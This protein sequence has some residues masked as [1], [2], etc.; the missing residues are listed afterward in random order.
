MFYEKNVWR[1][2]WENVV[3][4]IAHINAVLIPFLTTFASNSAIGKENRPRMT[5]NNYE[6]RVF[7]QDVMFVVVVI[8]IVLF[9]VDIFIRGNTVTKKSF[10]DFEVNQANLWWNYLF[11]FNGVCD[12]VAVIGTSVSLLPI[13]PNSKYGS[14]DDDYQKDMWQ[15]GFLFL[16]FKSR[17]LFGMDF[18]AKLG[19]F[20]NRV[21]RL[22]RMF[23]LLLVV[24]HMLACLWKLT[25]DVEKEDN[26]EI[27]SWD[28]VTTLN[29]GGTTLQDADVWQQYQS[30]SFYVLLLMFGENINPQTPLEKLCAYLIVMVGLVTTA[31]VV[32]NMTYYVKIIL[33]D[34]E[35]YHESMDNAEVL[36]AKLML[37]TK[38]QEL[39]REYMK[40]CHRKQSMIAP[41]RYAQFLDGLSDGLRNQVMVE[42]SRKFIAKC[43]LL[44]AFH[45][46]SV[47]LL[48][49][50]FFSS[51]VS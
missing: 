43:W 14:T 1:R 25:N 28:E 27:V 51:V 2:R 17:L 16:L 36:M 9:T 19:V 47:M 15:R 40:Y 21:L 22:T 26:F 23:C 29:D 50:Y 42:T 3:T 8:S 48:L 33:Q 24:V 5:P 7:L 37:P 30:Y 45:Q 41:E 10:N 13:R 32:A 39:V 11:S 44:G 6:E 49:V 31:L 38:L 20:V 12:L 46:V 18:P 35:A 4:I 34:S